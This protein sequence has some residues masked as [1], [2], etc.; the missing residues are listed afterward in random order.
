MTAYDDS[1]YQKLLQVAAGTRRR[2]TTAEVNMT[3]T[4]SV[5]AVA[6][7]TP[8]AVNGLIDDIARPRV[9]RADDACLMG[10]RRVRAGVIASDSEAIQT[11]GRRLDCFVASLLAM[12]E[13]IATKRLHS[14]PP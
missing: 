6:S 4:A 11:Y 8:M 7:T 5:A 12:T 10:R 14:P 9:W 13:I 3:Y 2:A 1:R